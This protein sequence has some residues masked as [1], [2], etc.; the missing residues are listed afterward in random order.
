MSVAPDSG[1]QDVRLSA[2]K[3]AL[4]DRL[5]R[6]RAESASR[7]G[8]RPVDVPRTLSYAQERLWF[9]EQLG[10]GGAAYHISVAV[11]L[12][13]P[14]D[15]AVLQKALDD[16]A[17]RHES[18]RMS[19]P[20]VEDGQPA[21][22]VTETLS[23]PLRLASVTADDPADGRQQALD[24]ARIEAGSPFDLAAGPL[25]RAQLV[26]YGEQAHLLSLETHHI[27]SDGWSIDVLV[28]DLL[29]AYRARQAEAEPTWSPLSVQ[30]S[31]YAHWQRDQPSVERGLRYWTDQLVGVPALELP[32]DR[33]RP[34]TQRFDGATHRFEI[35]A[36]LAAAVT[37]LARRHDATRYMTLL[38]AYQLLL[39]RYSDQTDFAVGSPVAGRDHP[40]LEGLVGM[41]VNMLPMRAQLDDDK[42]SFG[43]L[44][45]RTRQTVL[46]GLS[47]QRVQFEQLVAELGVARDVSRS[48]LFQATF[49]LQNYQM[50]DHAAG[51]DPDGLAARW[52][53]LDLSATRFDLEL[54]VVETSS[55]QFYCEFIYNTALFDGATVERMS[56]H[57]T[58]LLQTVTARPDAP[59][60]DLGLLTDSDRSTVLEQWAGGTARFPVEQTLPELFEAQARR[61]PDA[62]ALVFG[63]TEVSYAE[64]DRRADRL[65]HRLRRLGVGPDTLVALH[66]QPSV[67]T[68]EAILGVLKAGGAYV[69][70]NLAYPRER[71][72]FILTDT[73]A[74]V[75]ITDRELRDRLPAYT[76]QVVCLDDEEPDE[77]TGPAEPTAAAPPAATGPT[78]TPENLAYVIYTSGSTGTPKGVLVEHRQVVRLLTATEAHFDFDENDVWAMLHSYAFDF[79]VWEIWGAL[80]YGGRLVIVPT[81]AIRDQ[82][83]LL[84]VLR[85]QRVTVLNQTPAAFRGLRATLTETD[86]SFADLDVRTVVF[87]GDALHLRDLRHWMSQYG[88]QKPALV[89]MYGITET[90]VHVTAGRIRRRDVRRNVSSPI[91]RPLD[92]LRAYVLDRHL[93]PVPAGVP[94][95]LYVAGA[96]LA[97]GYLNRSAL[98]AE[99]FLPEPF[100][101]IPGARMYRTGDRVRWSADGTLEYL[102]RVDRQV[103]IRGY[104][105]ELG[106][107]EAA[108]HRSPEVRSAAVLVNEDASG[109]RRLVAYVVPADPGARLTPARLREQVGQSLADYM[110]PAAFV[111]LDAFPL[112]PNGKLDHRALPDP[113][114]TQQSEQ[115]F[116]EP[117]T[118]RERLIAGIWAELLNLDRVG[119]DDDF[120]DIGGHSLLATRVVT[121]IRASLEASGAGG[122]I[123]LMDLFRCRTVRELARLLDEPADA[124]RPARLLHQ[125]TRPVRDDQHV[126]S[127]VCVPYGGG[128]AAVYQ[129]LAEA[130]PPGH[131]LYSVAIHNEEAGG[132]QD[133][134]EFDD[135]V[136][137]IVAEILRDVSGP[138]ALYGHCGIGSATVVEV[139]RRLEQ[140]GRELTAVYI[141]GIFPFARPKGILSGLS[142]FAEME[143]L[144]SNRTFINRLIGRGV[145]I[146]DLGLDEVNRIIR[147]MRHDTRSAESYYGGLL[148]RRIPKISAPVISV[149]GEQDPATDHYEER[150]REWDFLSD[151]CA[152]VVL[153]EGGHYFNR[154]RATEVAEIVTNTHHAL[155]EDDGAALTR[156]ARG[157]ESPWWLHG[158]HRSDRDE[159][160]DPPP[161]TRR[162]RAAVPSMRRFLGVASGQ[163]VSLIGSTFTS[164]AI[165]IWI[166]LTYGSVAQLALFVTLGML[167]GLVVAPLAGAVVDRSNRKLVLLAA[168]AAAFTIQLGLGILL[169]T[170]T[171]QLWHLYGLMV[172]LSVAASFQRLAYVASVPQLVPKHYLRHAIGV[173][174]LVNSFGTLLVPLVA[175]SLLNSIGLDG[176]L[177]LD[178]VSYTV[179]IGVTAVVRW[180]AMMGW[181]RRETML[182]EIANG[183]RFSWGHRNFRAMLIFFLVLNLFLAPA[184]ILTNPLVLS[185]GSLDQ[186]ATVSVVSGVGATLA[187]M[188]V[189]IWGGPARR[190]MHGVLLAVLMIALSAILVGLRPDLVTV[191]IGACGIA[192][193]LT[194]TTGIYRAI[195][196]V[197][198]PQRY[199][200]RAAALN[201]MISWSTLPFGFA[202]LA[203]SAS[204][205][206]EPMLMPGGALA[207]TVGKVIGVGEG[208][209]I[210]FVYVL[211][212]LAI[213]VLVLVASRIPAVARFDTATPDALPDD[214]IGVQA[215]QDRHRDTTPSAESRTLVSS[216][217]VDGRQA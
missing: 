45:G 7:I 65:A 80:A 6:P 48:P 213:A 196:Q 133:A 57:L 155:A 185:F 119:I 25:V 49:A 172:A 146:E 147:N 24:L 31:D 39:G 87:G 37:E 51:A 74:P 19:F 62:V 176:I 153:D 202:V 197:K 69:P 85:E 86:R 134:M 125:L 104:R 106:E 97:R 164:W 100:S 96:G 138:L 194:L 77:P 118:E 203:P 113:D 129:A 105:I 46:D 184:L 53:I 178:I 52:E 136:A 64:L 11:W 124:D 83:R 173:V 50:R 101:G 79:S 55:G 54:L 81:D 66:L 181:H 16:L 189:A 76:G 160:T 20:P 68:V 208:R 142:R 212:G 193:G 110:V 112:T 114:V 72:E 111:V 99:R 23:V 128:S 195:V 13:G 123:A 162:R 167:P 8:P 183:F 199:H 175:A 130:M 35:D 63:D 14:V 15:P 188:L 159:P 186:A 3:Q 198:I 103:K 135:L 182:A 120:F 18:L 22:V 157:P 179:A 42:D 169:W 58:H 36:P 33:P 216:G 5:L 180:P 132:S 117:R 1:T 116:T 34:P 158:V 44:L 93:N 91:G 137:G 190:P 75:L 30:Y 43:Q 141:G 126:L 32:T 60:R 177:I 17:A 92:D 89:N 150:Y 211:A 192:A 161:G 71:L 163:L 70:L 152:L 40:E 206:F 84:D 207:D 27:V 108:L 204:A 121:R 122:S 107:I 56:R 47:H 102:G 200:G 88:D 174:E 214:L 10:T 21:V 26:N 209:G 4:L 171:L 59:L 149:I 205:F 148:D 82:E 191:A 73:G 38:A 9:V 78:V 28:G 140:A 210:A 115:E 98:T 154:Y 12:D 94:G 127:L 151:T 145:D 144:R 217:T 165:P 41:F 143:S 131:R 166:Y 168:S 90:T 170:D 187:G 67:A 139:A 215:L 61:R 156:A 29:T 201:Q 2:T 109:D 95:E